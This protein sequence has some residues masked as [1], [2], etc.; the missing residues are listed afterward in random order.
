MKMKEKEQILVREEKKYVG[1][2]L[3]WLMSAASLTA[4]LRSDRTKPLRTLY[5]GWDCDCADEQSRREN[6]EKCDNGMQF[7]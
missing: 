2:E 1:R 3:A 4:Q 7:L 6:F 5:H